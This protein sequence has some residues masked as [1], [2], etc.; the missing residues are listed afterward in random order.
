VSNTLQYFED[1]IGTL[2]AFSFVVAEKD[3]NMF[4]MH[5]LL[6]LSTKKW[7]EVHGEIEKRKEDVLSLLSEKLPNGEHANWKIC[8]A[9]DPH[10]RTVLG[11]HFTPH[12]CR[13]ERAE[14]LH[15]SAWYAWARGNY[16]T[17]GDRIQEAIDAREELLGRD[18]PN[19]VDS[20]GLLALVLDHQG[21]RKE[22][23]ELGVQVMETRKRVLGQEHP[24]TL[25]SMANLAS[26]Y[27][28]Q[29]RW[30]EAEELFVQVMET[31]KRVLGQEHPST[32]TS[33]ANLAHTWKSQ[34]RD[35]EAI[36]LMKQAE[37]LQR[38][39][40]G[41]GHP[42]TMGSM[43]TLH[44]WQIPQEAAESASSPRGSL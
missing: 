7:L 21:R 23:E 41:S 17:A 10:T 43:Q 26:T 31:R 44:E 28:N 8:E 22:T 34:G 29:G 24:S 18:D 13:L 1:A 5:P 30:K 33:M 9:L 35:K 16:G 15:N 20:L 6:Q 38:D 32:L 12:R 37:R 27:R 4:Q 39:I 2:I 3:G 11:Y 42:L 19:T 25:T 36:D 14:I 40:L